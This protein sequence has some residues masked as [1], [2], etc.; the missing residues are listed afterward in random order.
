M[1][2]NKIIL[3]FILI[4]TLFCACD[5]TANNTKVLPK[6]GDKDTITYIVNG[7]KKIDSISHRIPDFAFIDQDGKPFTQADVQ[8]KIYLVDF[9]F[10][11]CPT[12]CPKVKKNMLK[13]YEQI[14]TGPDIIILSHTIDP[15]HDSIVVLRNFADRLHID[16]KKWKFLTGDKDKIYE[17][18]G[19]YLVAAQQDE[20]AAG[21]F[22]HS[23]NVMLID[24]NRCIRGYY[25]GLKTEKMDDLLR[26]I[27]ILEQEK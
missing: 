7:Q 4:A 15:K 21:G 1:S 20:N 24:K 6:L 16:T 9:F 3:F 10:T 13:V 5:N 18:A 17:M 25:N 19:Q 2:Q 11:S 27:K 12:I 23:G 26:D 22:T 14:K 8:G